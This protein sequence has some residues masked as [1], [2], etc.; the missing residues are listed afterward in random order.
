MGLMTA[1]EER[2]VGWLIAGA[3]TLPRQTP[4]VVSAAFARDATTTDKRGNF[5]VC[6]A[7]SAKIFGEITTLDAAAAHLV[8]EIQG[9]VFRGHRAYL[10]AEL[11]LAAGRDLNRGAILLV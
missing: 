6:A 10:V 3:D 7:V 4:P 11:E 8:A 2:L 1:W 5:W 9:V